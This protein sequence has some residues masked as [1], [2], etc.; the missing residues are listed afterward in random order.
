MEINKYPHF[1]WVFEAFEK[2]S[3]IVYLFQ[4]DYHGPLPNPKLSMKILHPIGRGVTLNT[5]LSGPLY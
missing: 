2:K 5:N 4:D 3:T 1:I